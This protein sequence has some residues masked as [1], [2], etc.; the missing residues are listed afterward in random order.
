MANLQNTKRRIRSVDSTKKITKAMELVASAKLRKA[1]NEYLESQKVR[2]FVVENMSAAVF[3]IAKQNGKT[4]YI[5]KRGDRTLYIVIGGDM[6]LS[7]GYNINVAKEAYN[8]SK[9]GDMFMCVGSKPAIYLKSKNATIIKPKE[10][11]GKYLGADAKDV[12]EISTF[13]NVYDLIRVILL[14]FKNDEVDVV[15]L[16]HTKF[17][18]SVTFDPEVLDLLP[19]TNEFTEL[20]APFEITGDP[21]QLIEDLV[22]D[23]LASNVFTAVKEGAVCQYASSRLAM[24]NATDNAEELKEKLLLEY[25]RVRQANITQELNEI[26]AGADAI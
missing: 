8:D 23:Y 16:A 19:V 12:R 9:P 24:E 2:D 11:L 13:T 3:E 4:E 20:L 6:G 25:N 5:T 14:L 26:V 22:K 7:G 10:V 17:K 1:K 21:D 15:K 18:N